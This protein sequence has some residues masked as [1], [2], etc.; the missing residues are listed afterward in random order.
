MRGERRKW[1]KEKMVFPLLI[2]LQ[3]LSFYI[4]S[5]VAIFPLNGSLNVTLIYN[6]Q[7]KRVPYNNEKNHS[8]FSSFSFS[9]IFHYVPHCLSFHFFPAPFPSP[10]PSHSILQNIYPWIM[11]SYVWKNK[12]ITLKMARSLSSRSGRFLRGNSR[13]VWILCVQIKYEN[14]VKVTGYKIDTKTPR[15]WFDID[16]MLVSID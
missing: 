6:Y 13:V 4:F 11:G 10:L 5:P 7:Q 3:I 9:L 2:I 12:R 1:K 16:S 14:S 15:E 8:P